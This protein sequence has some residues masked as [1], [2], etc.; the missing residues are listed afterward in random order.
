MI[1][2]FQIIEMVRLNISSRLVGDLGFFVYTSDAGCVSAINPRL[3]YSFGLGYLL[4]L[5]LQVG[6][7]NSLSISLAKSIKGVNFN[8]SNTFNG[9]DMNPSLSLSK[10]LTEN[11]SC[12]ADFNAGS[13]K[14]CSFSVASQ[15]SS[16]SNYKM[17]TE[18]NHNDLEVTLG[19]SYKLTDKISLKAKETIKISDYSSK[20]RGLSYPEFGVSM[21]LSQNFTAGYYIELGT[22]ELKFITKLKSRGFH[23]RIPLSISKIVSYKNI[24]VS[25]LLAFSASF[26]TYFSAVFLKKNRKLIHKENNE[27]TLLKE[28]IQ[29]HNEFLVSI[30]DRVHQIKHEEN[31]KNGLIIIKALYGNVFNT[32]LNN[33]ESI[34][35]TDVLQYNVQNSKLYLKAGPKTKLSGFFNPYE[36]K[37][38]FLYVKYRFA[39]LV[40]EKVISNEEV[41]I[42][43]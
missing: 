10:A 1:S 25:V 34:V 11:T 30:Q 2:S 43:P 18:V 7:R 12:S 35:V 17:R 41:L 26:I 42:L 28:K 29:D 20:I 8:V 27:K 38:A 6:N 40:K 36:K 5:S 37:P 9:R 19:Y 21:N 39:G 22:S 33:D 16:N 32:N 15:Y 23:L 3:S 13:E 4:N 14:S 31:E 24:G